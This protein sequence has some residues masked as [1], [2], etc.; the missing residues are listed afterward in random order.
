[1]ETKFDVCGEL[2]IEKKENTLTFS[3]YCNTCRKIKSTMDSNLC[4]ICSYFFCDNICEFS[5]TCS[6]KN[7]LVILTE[8]LKKLEEENKLL[9]EEKKLLELKL[10]N[11]CYFE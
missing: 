8:Y 6:K 9:E 5:H 2:I 10:Q 4:K 7:L 3:I 11:K 1:M